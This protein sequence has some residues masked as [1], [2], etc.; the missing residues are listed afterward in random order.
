MRRSEVEEC[1]HCKCLCFL[2]WLQVTSSEKDHVLCL[3]PRCR[4]GIDISELKLI[5][6]AEPKDVACVLQQ[7]GSWLTR[8]RHTAMRMRTTASNVR[9]ALSVLNQE[10]R[11]SVD[12]A[13]KELPEG[14]FTILKAAEDKDGSSQGERVR[15]YSDGSVT[16]PSLDAAR[17]YIASQISEEALRRDRAGGAAV[18]VAVAVKKEAEDMDVE[19]TVSDMDE[20]PPAC[21]ACTTGRHVKH[22]CARNQGGEGSGN[23]NNY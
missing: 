21:V 7:G 19:V 13:P 1:A 14:W 8:Q 20:G 23:E 18:A 16:L 2:S 5:S 3:S 4:A 9:P 12:E 11:S 15:W 10:R 6:R 17:E 22:T